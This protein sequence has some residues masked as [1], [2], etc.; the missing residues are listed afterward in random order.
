TREKENTGGRKKRKRQD[1]KPTKQGL[2]EHFSLISNGLSE[3]KPERDCDPLGSGSHRCDLH[4]FPDAGMGRKRWTVRVE[5]HTGLRRFSGRRDS[6]PSSWNPSYRCARDQ[7]R[8]TKRPPSYLR[9]CWICAEHSCFLGGGHA[10]AG[11]CSSPTLGGRHHLVLRRECLGGGW[12]HSRLGPRVDWRGPRSEPV[13]LRL[14]H[15]PSLRWGPSCWGCR[16]DTKSAPADT[17]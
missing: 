15:T 5:T 17:D 9:R 8:R 4:I 13:S 3:R 16:R 1:V 11:A 2:H 6:D 7:L 10:T 14:G 12:V